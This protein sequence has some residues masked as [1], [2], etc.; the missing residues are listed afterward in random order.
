MTDAAMAIAERQA[1][2]GRC[3][4][5]A[6]LP[7]GHP[8]VQGIVA[9]RLVDRFARP[10]VCLSP[11]ASEGE[12]CSGSVRSV[13]GYS[14]SDGLTWIK[15]ESGV[16]VAGGG[17][18]MAGGVTLKRADLGRFEALFEQSVRSRLGGASFVSV[19]EHDGVLPCHAL[20]G[21][22]IDELATVEPFGQGFP[23]P[24]FL[25]QDVIA[26]GLRG[27]GKERLHLRLSLRQGGRR[28]EG[29]W[30]FARAGEEA[31]WPLREGGVYTLAVE[32]EVNWWL[33]QA[34]VQARV[35][36]VVLAEEASLGALRAGDGLLR[37]VGGLLR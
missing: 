5:F 28:A 20:T 21:R 14:V 10:A 34:R 19:I 30:F 23:R 7:D 37:G 33:G 4:L 31:A 24:V 17:H 32:P 35:L 26:E 3:A 12:L 22:L 1:D 16:L 13:A 18:A 6:W 29:V 25:L 27:L 8:G 2:A 9:S 11:H 15:Q 36:G